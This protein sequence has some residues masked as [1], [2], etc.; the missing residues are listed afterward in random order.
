[1]GNELTSR[2][3]DHRRLMRRAPPEALGEQDIP[4]VPWLDARTAG[5]VR[6]ITNAVAR[7]HPALLAVI[8]FGSVARHD[9]RPLDDSEPSDV[10]LLL[11]FRTMQ[12][13][14]RVPEETALAVY[15]TM[16]RALDRF[17]YP[18]REVQTILTTEGLQGWDPLFIENV[19]REGILLWSRGPLP[20][21]LEAVAQRAQ[22]AH[23][24]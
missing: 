15:A 20:Q 6:A 2:R 10:D 17:L 5:L 21:A 12:G 4:V 22:P 24:G 7:E 23:F 19:A 8:L 11:L 13:Q 16:G 3:T 1:M 14:E 9:E 18:P